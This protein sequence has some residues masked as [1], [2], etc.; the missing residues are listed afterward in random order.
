MTFKGCEIW[1][2]FPAHSGFLHGGTFKTVHKGIKLNEGCGLMSQRCSGPRKWLELVGHPVGEEGNAEI[3][4]G[5]FQ[6][7]AQH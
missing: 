6:A 4:G 7:L 1:N 5:P 3:R 2:Q